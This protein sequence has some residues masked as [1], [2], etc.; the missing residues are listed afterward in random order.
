MK[1]KAHKSVDDYIAAQPEDLQRALK[2]VRA[3]I[4][5]AVPEAAEQISYQMPAYKLHG[6]VLMYFAGWTE[7]YAIYPGSATT[8]AELA[9]D[10]KPYKASKGTIRFE[11]DTAV[12][13]ELVKRIALLRARE[14]AA[15]GTTKRKKA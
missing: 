3:T 11:R 10:L 6:R 8:V 14:V 7:H 13:V 9:D 1:T 5:K 4:R 12:P 15:A 2:K